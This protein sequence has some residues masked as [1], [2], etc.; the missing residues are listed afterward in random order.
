MGFSV[1]ASAA[2]IFVGMLISLGIVY[3]AVANGGER[4]EAARD[5][6]FEN[7]RFMRNAAIDV[8]NA[9]YD[10]GTD[11]L[12]VSAKNTG[13]TALSVTDT[14]VLADNEYL[15]PWDS[16]DV[17]GDNATDVWE[18]GTTLTVTYQ[19]DTDRPAP[20]AVVVVAEPGIADR[21]VV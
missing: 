14:D 16:H 11:T 20:S 15:Y 13:V 4:I 7:T 10:A 19:F 12:T 18:P 3:P 21:E 8:T 17:A 5:D 1:S 6:Q 9:S 2:I